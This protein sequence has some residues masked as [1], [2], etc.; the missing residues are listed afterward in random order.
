MPPREVEYQPPEFTLN[1]AI[2]ELFE[3]RISLEDI[4]RL[5]VAQ[6]TITRFPDVS[7]YQG[8]ID[9]NILT[10]LIPAVIIRMGQGTYQDSKFEVNFKQACQHGV[11]TGLYW[12]YDDRK[13]PSE[14]FAAFSKVLDTNGLPDMEVWIDWENTYN[15]QFGG[16]KNVVALMQLIEKE[17]AVKIGLYTGYYWFVDHSNPITNYFQYQYLKDKPLWLAWYTSDITKVRIPAPWKFMHFWQYGTPS[18]G[19]AMGVQTSEIDMDM[20]TNPNYTWDELYKKGASVLVNK[21][22]SVKTGS[23]A[24]L[25]SA[26]TGGV[27]VYWMGKDLSA[28]TPVV[29]D[30]TVG[31]MVHLTSPMSCWSKGEWFNLTDVVP[32]PGDG[33]PPPPPPPPSTKPTIIVTTIVRADG[34][35]DATMVTTLTP[36]P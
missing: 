16:L 2:C 21:R 11:K 27:R 29:V 13:S 5:E 15:G 1:R 3:H 7:F 30:Q 6:E 14:Q 19:R 32:D 24:K 20:Y 25:W 31:D 4:Y 9:W 17:Y 22:G 23:V 10:P 8:D 34:Y 33:T 28:G 36:K 12:F 35:E 18:I 26:S